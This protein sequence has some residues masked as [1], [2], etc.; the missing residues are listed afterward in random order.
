M[1]TTIKNF[2]VLYE[3]NNSKFGFTNSV[4]VECCTPEQ[5][6][7]KA[8]H[9]ISCCYGSKMLNKFDIKKIEQV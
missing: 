8:I 7:E 9:E 4:T 1:K 6:K 2:R 5:A 3:F